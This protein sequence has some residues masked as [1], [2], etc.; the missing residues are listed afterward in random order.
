MFFLLACPFVSRVLSFIY[1]VRVQGVVSM[2]NETSHSLFVWG[3]SCLLPCRV[4]VT[5]KWVVSCTRI[6]YIQPLSP[7]LADITCL[8]FLFRKC[9]CCFLSLF[10]FFF[11]MRSFFFLIFGLL[12]IS[13]PLVSLPDYGSNFVFLLASAFVYIPMLCHR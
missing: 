10:P 7:L 13:Y 4:V 1:D 9:C 8:L 11:T 12:A 3:S 5:A 2:F 6:T